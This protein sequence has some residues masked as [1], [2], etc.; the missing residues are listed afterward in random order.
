MKLWECPDCKRKFGRKGQGHACQPGLTIDEYFATG[1][2]WE[3][4][5]FDAVHA[6][7]RQLGPIHVEP[8][9]VGIFFKTTSTII[10]LRPMTKW[11]AVSFSLPR[12]LTSP[13]ISRK[14]VEWSGKFHHVVNVRDV[15]EVDEELLG[16]LAECYESS[17]EG[18]P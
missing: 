4:P 16:W 15:S 11:V 8:V 2:P 18:E 10:Q 13:R 1:P 3:R 14:V 12:K 7:L 6:R 9:Q 17:H 5:I